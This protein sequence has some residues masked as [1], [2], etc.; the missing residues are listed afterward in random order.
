MAGRKEPKDLQPIDTASGG[1]AASDRAVTR[2]HAEV[3]PTAAQ[4]GG[5][6]REPQAAGSM[7][8]RHLAEAAMPSGGVRA[9][10]RWQGHAKQLE[11]P[12]SSHGDID[13]AREAG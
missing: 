4:P 9:T 7:Q 13:G 8:R 2:V 11:K 1:M 3:A 12:S 10:A 6:G 5:R